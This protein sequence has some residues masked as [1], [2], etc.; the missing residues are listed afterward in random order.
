MR[1]T[2][3]VPLREHEVEEIFR[4]AGALLEGHFVLASGRHAA[5]YLEKFRVF[6]DPRLT[7]RLCAG[8]AERV[9][10]RDVEAV[11]GP[12]T[13]GVILAHEVGR[14]L[15]LPTLYAER[16]EPA[17]A[18]PP[19]ATDAPG[20]AARAGQARGSPGPVGRAFRR[21]QTVSPGARVLV[22]DDVLTTGGSVR[23]TIDAVRA[24]GAQVVGVAVL[25]DRSGGAEVGV[26][27][28]ALWR[29]A[30]ESFAPADCPL[31]RRG[32]PATKPGTTP[33]RARAGGSADANGGRRA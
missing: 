17:P 7:E 13:G 10:G 15:G 16:D 29:V 14:Q 23:E 21:G 27:V 19:A 30:I 33:A 11:A 28:E 12:T 6:A 32:V 5:R 25:A 2:A 1:D 18:V 31:C 20:T 9:R 26:P 3:A 4:A 24:A 8:I 22:V